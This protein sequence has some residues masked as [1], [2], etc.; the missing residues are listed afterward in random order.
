MGSAKKC[1]LKT[2]S[3]RGGEEGLVRCKRLEALF[4]FN[5]ASFLTEEPIRREEE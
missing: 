5:S 1:C 3:D 4:W 2:R